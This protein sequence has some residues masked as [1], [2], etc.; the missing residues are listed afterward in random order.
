MEVK[1]KIDKFGRIHLPKKIRE[2]KGYVCGTE[3]SLIMEPETTSL[4]LEATAEKNAV[5]YVEITDWGW[6]V[7]KFPNQEK[8]DFDIVSFIKE[9]YEERSRKLMGE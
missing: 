5:P 3:L 1:V 7:I 2:V 6:P 4:L 9:G 8:V